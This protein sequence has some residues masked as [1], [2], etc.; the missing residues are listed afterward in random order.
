MKAAEDYARSCGAIALTLNVLG[1]NKP[2]RR[3]YE[4][5]GFKDYQLRLR[6]D[7]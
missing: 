7:L 4:K 1:D 3:F 5:S 2:A 6:K